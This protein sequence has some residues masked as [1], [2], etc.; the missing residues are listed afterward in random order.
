VLRSRD[1]GLTFHRVDPVQDSALDFRMLAALDVN[2]AWAGSAGPGEES[3]LFETLNGGKSWTRRLVNS[4][5][6]GFWDA[7]RFWDESHGLLVG[8]AVDGYLSVLSTDDGGATWSRV[9]EAALPASPT[10]M[11][12]AEGAA[13]EPMGEVCFAASNRSLALGVG[14]EAWIGT[15]GSVA[16]VWH[17]VDWGRTWT[18]VETPLRHADPAA[19]IFA[20]ALD[21][22]GRGVVVGGKFVAPDDPNGTAAF[23]EDGGL[24][25]HL[26]ENPPAGYRSGVA[27][28]PGKAITSGTASTWIAVGTSGTSYSTDGGRIWQDLNG[29][30][31][32]ALAVDPELRIVY[33][34]GSKGR[35]AVV[36]M[37]E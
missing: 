25:W 15:G 11:L 1:S 32:N 3:Q 18:A 21:E 37:L 34:V 12:A 2:H 9:P 30:A 22:H 6:A 19:G 36:P 4:D 31:L 27:R 28:V 17:S 23:T 5:P 7:L 16:R 24:T 20:V 35:F 29:L 26:A 13:S 14:G 8:D 33:C 10:L